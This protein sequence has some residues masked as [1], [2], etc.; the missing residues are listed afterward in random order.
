M[1]EAFEKIIERLEKERALLKAEREE[2]K[3]YDEQ[4]IFATNNQIRAF[5]YALRVIAEEYS[6][7]EIP[8]KWIP[9]SERLPENIKTV[10]ID[11][12]EI[13]YPTVGWYGNLTGWHLTERDFMNL[14]DFTVIAWQPL[15][16]PYKPKG[17]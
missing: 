15:P 17:E 14:K 9:C 12:K 7:S 16:V 1:K 8:N 11:V 2:A 4:I 6:N 13:R 3:E 5:D 10:I